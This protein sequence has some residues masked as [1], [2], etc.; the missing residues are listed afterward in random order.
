[1]LNVERSRS[2]IQIKRCVILICA[3]TGQ[4][5]DKA[6]CSRWISCTTKRVVVG[7]SVGQ[8][9]STLFHQ[10]AN[11]FFFTRWCITISRFSPLRRLHNPNASFTPSRCACTLLP[12]RPSVKDSC[13]SRGGSRLLWW[14]SRSLAFEASS[15]MPLPGW[16]WSLVCLDGWLSV[17]CS[18]LL[19]DSGVP[20]VYILRRFLIALTFKCY[21]IIFS[22]VSYS[23][24]R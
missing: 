13:C 23:L 15:P 17:I 4:R 5:W 3:V 18:L 16:L 9:R 10:S 12:A 2:N 6:L 20:L 14:I 1:M 21:F 24:V 8:C 19:W 7:W 22:D 11:Y